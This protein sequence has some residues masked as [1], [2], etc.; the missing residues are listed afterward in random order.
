[1][2]PR[3]RDITGPARMAAASFSP[4]GMVMQ[5]GK[6]ELRRTELNAPTG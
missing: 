2:T 4:W 6:T 5:A 1:M 3:Q